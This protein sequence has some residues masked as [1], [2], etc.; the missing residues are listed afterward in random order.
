MWVPYVS[1]KSAHLSAIAILAAGVAALMACL[2]APAALA[3]PPA[4]KPYIVVLEDDVAHPANVAHRHEGNRDIDVGHIYGV[5]IKG[6]SADLTPGQLKAIEQDPNVDYVER[7]GVI[8]PAFIGSQVK[9]VFADK[10]PRLAINETNDVAIDADIA[11]LDTGV[12]AHPDLNIAGRTNCVGGGGACGDGAGTD[13]V[14]HGTHVAGVAAAIDN[15]SGVVGSA[16]GA[17]I[18][19]VKVL[20]DGNEESIAP[21]LM[22]DAIA[23]VNWVTAHS[24]V[25]EVANMSFACWSAAGNCARTALSEAIGASVNSGVVWVA[26][27]GNGNHDVSGGLYFQPATYPAAIPDVIAVSALGDFDGLPGGFG[28]GK[29]CTEMN[30]YDREKDDQLA[31]YSNWGPAVD[32]AAPRDCI[33][34]TWLGNGYA[35]RFGTSMASALVTG[36]VADIAALYNPNNRGEVEAVRSAL[37]SAGNYNWNDLH[38]NPAG[39]NTL[40]GDGVKEPLLDMSSLAAPP[41]ASTTANPPVGPGTAT[42]DGW[43]NPNGAETRFYFQYG[44][45]TAYGS[46]IPAPPGSSIGS[47]TSS[48]H[49]VQGLSG[50]Q[51]ATTYHFR[52][53]ASNALGTTYGQDQAFT[54]LAYP[55]EVTTDPADGIDSQGA[56]LHGS[57]NP[58]GTDTHYQFQYGTTTSYGSVA[59]VGGAG[60]GNGFVGA[61]WRID[62]LP[63]N[64]TYHYRLVAW[65]AGGYAYG[66]DRTFTTQ[67]YQSASTWSTRMPSADPN[68]WQWVFYRG[69]GGKLTERYYNGSKW[70]TN[71]LP[72]VVSSGST[73]SVVRLPTENPNDNIWVYYRNS[74]GHLAVTYYNGTIWQ[75]EDLGSQ[76]AAGTSP[77]V[78]RSP[79]TNPGDRIWVFTNGANGRLQETYYAG[80]G[81][82]GLELGAQMEPGTSPAVVR[83]PTTDPNG[84]MAVFTHGP[85]GPNGEPGRLF[86]TY[87]A[88]TGWA[89]QELGAQMSPGSSPAAVRAPTTN[90]NG[91]MA[92]FINGFD[93]RLF[94]AYYA[95]TGWAGH[96]LGAQMETGTSPAAVRAPT[97]NPNGF[98]AVFTHGPKGP[99]GEPG[100]LFETYYAGT[101]WAGL[102]L[103]MQMKAGT[104]P[105]AQRANT[106]NPNGSMWVFVNGSNDNLAEGYYL[107]GWASL[108]LG[109]PMAWF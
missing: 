72:G 109:V 26:A 53:V 67:V 11:I 22:S 15:N 25:I 42:L 24:N 2:F 33:F 65:N 64:T 57:V 89:G 101:G 35:I 69:T 91:F 52:L 107:G 47:G 51:L 29:K 85:K 23:G 100:R 6:Y 13:S 31:T 81:W 76:M 28:G 96:E 104:S 1:R 18:W 8:H 80:G 39:D 108:D 17:R 54:T 106:S 79:S 40:V 66:P 50:L 103:G 43:V 7:D 48:Q 75:V 38:Y 70:L 45:T 44:T 71:E 58:R 59:S 4:T 16:P 5:A 92:V 20:E 68:A 77:A 97:T 12:A 46:N 61:G 14:G 30:A 32:I 27:A 86:E 63:Q 60:A 21:S 78:V 105:S 62:G 84:F 74:A 102:E 19:S 83:A 95:G 49:V 9:R 55:P 88:G 3:A 10:N 90:P 93:G 56:T 41:S 98:M 87:Y 82:A 37:I 36:A 99:N 73:P 34:S 94:E